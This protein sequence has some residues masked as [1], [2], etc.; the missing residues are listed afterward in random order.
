M[1]RNDYRIAFVMLPHQFFDI[2]S[3]FIAGREVGVVFQR[4]QSDG[5]EAGVH[6]VPRGA[7]L[8]TMY[9]EG[10]FGPIYLSVGGLPRHET[11]WDFINRFTDD[12]IRI[13][14]G[15][16]APGQIELSEVYLLGEPSRA[17]QVFDALEQEIAASSHCGLRGA[18]H[19]YP[20]HY[21]SEEVR[22]LA[23]YRALGKEASRFWIVEE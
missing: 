15:A 3:R 17:R 5:F 16:V 21:W 22:P 2:L 8:E 23:L 19:S 9:R 13:E 18:R 14:L 6:V 4:F 1:A 20:N 12:L 7:E 11:D 10:K